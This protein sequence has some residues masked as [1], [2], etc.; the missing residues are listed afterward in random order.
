MLRYGFRVLGNFYARRR[1][2]DADAALEGYA[3]CHPEAEVGKEAYLSAFAFGPDFRDYLKANNSVA[4]FSGPCWSRFLSW[5]ID[6]DDLQ[7]ALTETRR[8]ATHLLERYAELGESDLLLW[9]SGSKG[10]HAGLPTSLWKP[11]PSLT[12]NR[13][14][15]RFAVGI[16]EQAGVKPY[17]RLNQRIDESIYNLS[18]CWR[19][20]NS[21][22]PKTG[23]HKRYLTYD[24]LMGLDL[25][26]ILKLAEQP[27]PFDLPQPNGHSDRAAADWHAAQQEV[28]KATI[29]RAEYRGKAPTLN[30]LTREYIAD[31]ADHGDRHRL[32]W[33]A[34]A[35]LGEFGCP[36]EL[37]HALLLEPA[38]D[39][40]LSPADAKRHID[41]GLAEGRKQRGKAES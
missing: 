23:L 38:I 4:D 41:R 8:L 25:A 1:L 6:R 3:S 2:V 11:E 29:S 12:F 19:A 37:A 21:W 40:G 24:A 35:N 34:A 15:R 31:G 5:D 10:F 17:G 22:H 14:A 36:S 9:F 28:A 39:C 7:L 16:A 20:P 27:E 18:R 33:S 30:R 32:L 26:Q 13:I